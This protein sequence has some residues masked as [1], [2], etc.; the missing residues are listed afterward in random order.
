MWKNA[1]D[2]MNADDKDD[3]LDSVI[4]RNEVATPN[5]NSQRRDWL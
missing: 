1:H 3:D 2:A 4:D 5:T